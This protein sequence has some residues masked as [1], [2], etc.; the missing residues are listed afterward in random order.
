MSYQQV[1]PVIDSSV[2]GLCR[3]PYPNHPSGCPN[4][5][6]KERCPPKALALGDIIDL[7]NTVFVIYNK[8]DFGEHVRR[9]LC[10]PT[11]KGP[12]TQRQA[13]CCLYWQGTAR[14]QLRQVVRGF[15][16]WSRPARPVVVSTPEACGVN[17]TATMKHIG[18]ELEWPPKQWAY[19]VM[20]AGTAKEPPPMIKL[21]GGQRV[22][23]AEFAGGVRG[24]RFKVT[25][26]TP[27]GTWHHAA[28]C[29]PDGTK[30]DIADW[31]PLLP[32]HGWLV[33]KA[34]A[35]KT[36]WGFIMEQLYLRTSKAKFDFWGEIIAAALATRKDVA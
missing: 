16:R 33:L 3:R 27:P 31:N 18:I 8:F 10:T 2:R 9:M 22:W 13:E 23:L 11:K 25:N 29:F 24:Q 5:N 4:W 7:R 30:I 34:L 26:A 20:L 21:T 19:Q 35:E 15:L 14:K 12:R 28:W 1:I 36:G 6:K 17:I 32:A